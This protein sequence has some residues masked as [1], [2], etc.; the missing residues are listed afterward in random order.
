[1]GSVWSSSCENAI[2]CFNGRVQLIC[3]KMV[4]FILQA[5][6]LA[7]ACQPESTQCSTVMTVSIQ[8]PVVAVVHQTLGRYFPY[9]P[10]AV[11]VPVV[12]AQALVVKYCSCNCLEEVRVKLLVSQRH[13]AH[14]IGQNG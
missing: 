7:D 8:V 11:N 14:S 3:W 1:M 4:R 6:S 5:V 10:V 13:N 12:D 2:A 9:R